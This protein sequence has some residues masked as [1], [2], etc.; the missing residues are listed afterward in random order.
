MRALIRPTVFMIARLGLFLAVAAWIAG[1][2]QSVSFLLPLPVGMARTELTADNWQ[3]WHLS[4][5]FNVSMT[6]LVRT[7]QSSTATIT[8]DERFKL[9]WQ[10][11]RI[12]SIK[13]QRATGGN[14]PASNPIETPTPDSEIHLAH[15]LIVTIFA[16][17]NGVLMWAYGK[18]ENTTILNEGTGE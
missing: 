7:R 9:M 2:W 14:I 10:I 6:E 17:L 18:R 5:R 16:L 13:V 12:E 15:W 4:K 11:E 1:Q 3:C 8:A